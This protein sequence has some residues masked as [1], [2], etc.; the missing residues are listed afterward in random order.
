MSNK[1]ELF[2][3]FDEYY[4]FDKE[5]QAISDDINT[6]IDMRLTFNIETHTA[7]FTLCTRNDDGFTVDWEKTHYVPWGSALRMLAADGVAVPIA[8]LQGVVL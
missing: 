1:F 5:L 7:Y 4:D 6:T 2:H 3:S 8:L